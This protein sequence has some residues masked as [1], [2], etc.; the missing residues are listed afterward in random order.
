MTVEKRGG[1]YEL[2]IVRYEQ[3][4]LHPPF[5]FGPGGTNNAGK[6]RFARTEDS[7]SMYVTV[8]LFV[9]AGAGAMN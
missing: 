2:V 1:K 9:G 5:T 4:D 8:P 7:Q 6:A 3:V